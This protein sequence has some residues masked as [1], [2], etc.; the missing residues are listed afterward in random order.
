MSSDTTSKRMRYAIYA[1]YS[2]EM[3]NEISLEDQEAVCRQEIAKRGGSVVAVYKDS[4]KT[5][6]SKTRC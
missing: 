6:W 1:R 3:Q 2:S 5:G 4:A